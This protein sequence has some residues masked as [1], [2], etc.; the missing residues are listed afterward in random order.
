LSSKKDAVDL[1]MSC[2]N[3][4]FHGPALASLTDEVWQTFRQAFFQ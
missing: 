2:L 4:V 1:F 3:A